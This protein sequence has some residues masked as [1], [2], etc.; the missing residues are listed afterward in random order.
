MKFRNTRTEFFYS[1]RI[2]PLIHLAALPLLRFGLALAA[3]SGRRS[4]GTA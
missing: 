3:G 2:T 1:I 4:G